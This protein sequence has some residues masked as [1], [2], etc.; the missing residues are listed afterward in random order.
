[1][2]QVRSYLQTLVAVDDRPRQLKKGEILFEQGTPGREMYIVRSGTIVLRSG[3]RTLEEVGP[4]GVIGEMALI[5]SSPRSASAVAGEDCSVTM[6]NEYTLLE[7]VKRV[8]GL[9]L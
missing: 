5:D 3:D 1:M 8:P 6:V 9:S 2:N 4:G 7:L